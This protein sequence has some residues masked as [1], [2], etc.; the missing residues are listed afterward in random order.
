[1]KILVTMPQYEADG[2]ESLVFNT[3]FTPQ[4][5]ER[6]E[7]LGDVKYNTLSRQFTV[8]ELKSELSEIDIV[9][10]GWGTHAYSKEILDC[11]P[12]LKLIAYTGGSIV[13]LMSDDGELEKRGI[14][15]HSG[16]KIFAISV[17]EAAVCYM[18]VAQRKL[19]EI[20]SEVIN[21]GWLLTR[22]YT[23]GLYGK[24]IGLVGFGMIAKETA[25]LLKPFNVNILVYSSHLRQETADEYGV[26]IADLD[27]LCEK[28]DIIS[29]HAGLTAENYHLIN[30]PL[31]K[32][33]KDGALI[34]NTARG[35]VID[36]SAMTQELKTG[37][38]RAILDVFETEPVPA[39]SELRGRNNVI[40]VPHQGGPTLDM[41]ECVTKGL[42]DDIE[43][44]INGTPSYEHRI[45]YEYGKR[46]TN[47]WLVVG[48]R[49]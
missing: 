1:M 45:S 39:D 9:I 31:L 38:I 32:K 3:F 36:E 18:L 24:T 6:L 19:T 27:E 33:M 17:A 23:E 21:E 49:K 14:Q 37:R 48:G 47:E 13:P 29:I 34:V 28:S 43:K 41:R 22:R 42:L 26:K 4:M 44:Y 35:A 25:K 16:N 30:E 8:D 20:V 2:K 7:K 5:K 11:A 46:M 40:I 10:A 12:K 15:I